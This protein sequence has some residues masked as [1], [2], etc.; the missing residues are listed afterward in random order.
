MERG[1]DSLR[2]DDLWPFYQEGHVQETRAARRTDFNSK[3]QS[4]IS[5]QAKVGIDPGRQLNGRN[6]W[7]T[8]NAN[9][10]G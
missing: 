4:Q 3:K 2:Q 8:T 5:R 10:F 9:I 1:Q 7:T 6:G